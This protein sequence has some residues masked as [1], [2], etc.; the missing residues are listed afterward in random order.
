MFAC[1]RV[2]I[3]SIL[4]MVSETVTWCHQRLLLWMCTDE[5]SLC[6][7]SFNLLARFWWS[8]PWWSRFLWSQT[9]NHWVAQF[10]AFFVFVALSPMWQRCLSIHWLVDSDHTACDPPMACWTTSEEFQEDCVCYPKLRQLQSR[11]EL[12]I[13]AAGVEFFTM[14]ICLLSLSFKCEL[15]TLVVS[16]LWHCPSWWQCWNAP[17]VCAPFVLLFNTSFDID[18]AT[19]DSMWAWTKEWSSTAL[20]A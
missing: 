9:L 20:S 8:C 6:T 3:A 14:P 18:S 13:F 4:L 17:W 19:S 16:H 2:A 11:V 1:G 7:T 10:R 5:W 15:I 12:S